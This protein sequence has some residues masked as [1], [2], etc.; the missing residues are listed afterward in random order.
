MLAKIGGMGLRDEDDCNF[1]PG[2]VLE[3]G[4][5]TEWE[6]VVACSGD[7]VDDVALRVVMTAVLE[8]VVGGT[9]LSSEFLSNSCRKV[10]YVC[11]LSSLKL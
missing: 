11:S 1:R 4:V 6:R 8:L 5:T 10:L 9:R 7:D 3:E 2:I